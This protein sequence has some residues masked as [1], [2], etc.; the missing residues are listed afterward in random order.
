MGLEKS[1]KVAIKNIKLRCFFII[2][3]LIVFIPF[4]GGSASVTRACIM[5]I[6]TY[7]AK[8]FLEKEDFYSS[9]CI[10]L[11]IILLINLQYLFSIYFDKFA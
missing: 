2:I 7:M 6:I 8:I 10:A 3:F 9:F 11:F 5:T 4:V 1:L